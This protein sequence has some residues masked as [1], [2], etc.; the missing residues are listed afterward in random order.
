[1]T[2]I[3]VEQA[4]YGGQD[5]GGYRFLARSPGFQDDWLTEAQRLCVGFGERPPGVACPGCLFAKPFGKQHVA[6]VHVADQGRD[7]AGRPGA[8]CFRL[9]VLPRRA[10]RRLGADPFALAERF[11]PPWHVRGDLPSL[12]MA[13]EPPPRRAVEEIQQVL[14][15]LDEGPTLLGGA[16]VLIDG[17]RL[18]FQ[19]SAPDPELL[20][21]LWT[22]LPVSTRQEVWPATFAFGNALGFDALVVPLAT[23]EDFAGYVSEQQAGEYPEGRFELSLQIAAE[24]G[25]Q[26][27]IDHLM[28]RRS[29]AETWKLGLLLLVLV[30]VMFLV[31]NLLFPN[32]ERPIGAPESSPKLDLPAAEQY[33]TLTPPE[34]A[35]LT[36]ALS[37][38]AVQ[39]G[40]APSAEP[41]TAETL[42]AAIDTR[43]GSPKNGRDPGK[44]LSTG[45]IQRRLRALLWKHG[46]D[47]RQDPDI[48]KRN[49]EELVEK[50][51]Q[52][53]KSR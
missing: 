9:L 17:G 35:R 7:D 33:P 30:A 3:S 46:L 20:R 23:K 1:M 4:T 14:K 47:E 49:P 21:G 51:H 48:G 24:A 8:L 53:V 29:R 15:R 38:L 37:D 18:V 39:L 19:R 52:R 13:D 2:Q 45:P 22:L 5:A 40:V 50:L 27:Q 16:Q 44:D 42:L 34:R 10:Y 36:R 31:L 41:A 12:D 28:T 25:D 11:P 32:K 43:L 6:I 26:A